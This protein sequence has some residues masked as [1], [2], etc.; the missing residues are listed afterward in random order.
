MRKYQ[1]I[2][3]TSFFIAL[4]MLSTSC[5][6][7]EDEYHSVTD[8]IEAESNNYKGISISSEKYFNEMNMIEITENEITFLIPTRKDKIKS[9]KCTECHTKPLEK[10][11]AK[12]I[13]KAHWDIKL[14]HA[15]L[16][17]MN[18]ITCHDSNNINELKSITGHKIDF[19]ESYKQCSQCHQ[20]QHK[21]WAGGA[22][23][24]Q[25]ESWTNPRVSM[26]CV[27]CHNPH[28]PGFDTKWPAVF[29]TQIVKERK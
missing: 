14:N 8:R 28:N 1:H 2:K 5:K 25:M 22:H 10:M 24:K 18:C 3:L 13:K 17:T 26:T 21:D 16:N 23:G 12:D 19:N 29:N 6:H 20:K 9:Y 11:Q 15:S 7:H 27:N 4:C